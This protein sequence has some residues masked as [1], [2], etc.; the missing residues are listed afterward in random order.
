MVVGV[1]ETL[2]AIEIGDPPVPVAFKEIFMV[3]VSP[4]A[5]V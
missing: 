1:P 3:C 2:D 4:L 5:N